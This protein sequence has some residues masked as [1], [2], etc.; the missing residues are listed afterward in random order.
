[1][2]DITF[3]KNF[4]KYF[5]TRCSGGGKKLKHHLAKNARKASIGNGFGKN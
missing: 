1:M 5:F 4:K 3:F 2:L